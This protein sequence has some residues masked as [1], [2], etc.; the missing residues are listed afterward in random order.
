MRL[1]VFMLILLTLAACGGGSGEQLLARAKDYIA[2]SDYAAATSELRRAQQL[3]TRSA[4]IHWLLGKVYI[5]TGHAREAE[6]EL[7]QAQE[8]GWPR[9][10]IRPAMA[11]SLLSQGRFKEVIALDFRD[12]NPTAAAQLLAS[13]A[14][15][16]MSSNQVARAQEL[17]DLAV[18]KQPQLLQAQLA[19]AT[20]L[21][22]RGDLQGAKAAINAILESNPDSGVAWALKGQVLR[23]QG[24]LE[25]ARVAFDKSTS[26]S[27]MAFA[28]QVAR[29]LINLQLQDFAAAQIDATALLE[30]SPNDPVA[31][32]LQG[33]LDF[34]NKL[35]RKA[36]TKLLLAEPAAQQFPL[37][38]YYLSKGYLIENDLDP[39]EKFARMFVKSQPDDSGGRK[40]L[41]AILIL[42]NKLDDA[43]E[44]LQPVLDHNP[45]EV[46]A[47]NIK[48]NALLLDGQA[49][50]A[51]VLYLL[52]MQLQRDW[53]VVP[54]RQ[55]A[56]LVT[57]G[58][59]GAA[60]QPPAAATGETDN[61][62]QTE[63]LLILQHL[64]NKNFQAAIDAAKSYQFRDIASVAPYAVV[65]M[66]YLAAGKPAEAR[67]VYL[68]AL[69]RDP[70]DS[71]ANQ[72]LARVELAAKKPDAARRHYQKILDSH[73]HDLDTLLQLADLENKQNNNAAMV[74]A[75]EDAA[76]A[77]RDA[78]EPRLRLAEYY[79]GA[80]H[81]KRV[82][83]LF[84]KLTTLQQSSPRVLEIALRAALALQQ[85]DSAMASLQQ[86]V[87]AKPGVVHNHFLLAT[88]ATRADQLQIAKE[89]YQEVIKRDPRHQLALIELA[90]I[91][92]KEGD[93]QQF[94]QYVT[95]LVALAPDTPDVLSLRALVATADGNHNEALGLAQ[96][97]HTL[98]P[99]TQTMLALTACHKAAGF[100]E[101]ARNT[102]QRW[103]V[104]HP[105]DVVARLALAED[106][107][108]EE[109]PAGASVQYVAVLA[110]QPNNTHALNKLA[111]SQRVEN[112]VL[113]L[114]AIRR[115]L[116]V[117]PDQ[118]DLLDTLAV[119]E[120]QT[121]DYEGAQRSIQR[122][123]QGS[124]GNSRMRFHE[125]MIDAACGEKARAIATLE[126]LTGPQSDSFP[127]Q[128]EAK[129]LLLSL[130][131]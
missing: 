36:I 87:D 95:A 127:E 73:G 50:K 49:Y 70:R 45:E 34:E 107:E 75:L 62:P 56:V 53:H 77:H 13:Q 8:L 129:K 125:A 84:A 23:Q 116:V 66:V 60:A 67:E 102:L 99:T 94:R 54:L 110:Q 121:G 37:A 14:L 19:V 44:K 130:Q 48:A 114:A 105:T 93:Q 65:G 3:D 2:Q 1:T 38:L 64:G 41:A 83:P 122:A 58:P 101:E 57:A 32:Y 111:W 27:A 63:L 16:A 106:L 86:L 96:R 118:P 74:S 12:L 112:P 11:Q 26:K 31:N 30:V 88:V 85:Y 131:G 42:Q 119:I 92:H 124:P 103:L 128:A 76:F 21:V 15:A 81:P 68:K 22:H 69:K 40:L 89:Q 72:G 17:A 104:N 9:D 29:G 4:E 79:M 115:A 117:A 55:E 100:K 28:D 98:V 113:A 123:L 10:D 109:N 5:E 61:F 18:R 108:L 59:G 39:A 43:L 91:A 33:M 90:R 82:A 35:Y 7:Q 78:L 126:A 71:A 80:G 120:L 52:L 46:A 47:L 25:E 24:K 51:F 6:Y 97:A 20:I